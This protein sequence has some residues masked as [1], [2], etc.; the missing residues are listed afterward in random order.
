MGK[1]GAIEEIEKKLLIFKLFNRA[2]PVALVI[3]V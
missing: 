3:R 2:F 1:Q